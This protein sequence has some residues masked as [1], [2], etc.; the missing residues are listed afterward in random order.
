VIVEATP[1][2]LPA[3]DFAELWAALAHIVRNAVD[4]GFETADERTAAGKSPKNRVWLRAF[5]DRN[6]GFVV[7]FADDG[8]GIDWKKVAQKAAAAG[9][10]A[11][12]PVDL[13]Q[14]LFADSISTRDHV[15]E[16]SGR[17]IGLAAVR[18]AVA[19]LGGRIEIDSAL[20]QGTTFRLAL[21]WPTGA[22]EPKLPRA[23]KANA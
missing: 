19:T 12:T 4:H 20:G 3:G 1:L 16:T 15:S 11:A 6:R 2:R 21:P 17:G 7:S 5:E 22:A 10:P 23:L 13:E 8:R 18:S 9:L 14:A